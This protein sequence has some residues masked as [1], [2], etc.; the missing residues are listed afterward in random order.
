MGEGCVCEAY[1]CV[2]T[3]DRVS[4]TGDRVSSTGGSGQLHGRGVWGNEVSP[5][6]GTGFAKRAQCPPPT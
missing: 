3:G 4:S 5:R 6:G 2:S 1:A